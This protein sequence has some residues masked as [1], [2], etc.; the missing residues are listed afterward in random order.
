MTN[1]NFQ[2]IGKAT[3]EQQYDTVIQ[4][5]ENTM[6]MAY[7]RVVN[8]DNR[9]LQHLANLIDCPVECTAKLIAFIAGSHDTAKGDLAFQT[10]NF[11]EEC[12][13][14]VNKLEIPKDI[15]DLILSAKTQTD[16]LRLNPLHHG[17]MA[18]VVLPDLYIAELGVDE[19]TAVMMA[20]CVS[21]HH[22]LWPC[23]KRVKR[24]K[25]YFA[26][27]NIHDAYQE[28]KAQRLH[29]IQHLRNV[30]DPERSMTIPKKIPLAWSLLVSGIVINA[31]HCASREENFK[32]I[33]GGSKEPS[34]AINESSKVI[35]RYGLSK[36]KELQE[37]TFNDFGITPRPHQLK[38]EQVGKQ[39]GM[40]VLKMPTGSGKSISAFL[41]ALLHLSGF[42]MLANRR[43]TANGMHDA[44]LSFL[45]RHPQLIGKVPLLAHSDANHYFENQMEEILS[46]KETY[47]NDKYFDE[48]WKAAIALQSESLQDALT[49]EYSVATIDQALITAIASGKFPGRAYWLFSRP[50]IIDEIHSFDGRMDCILERLLYYC[51]FFGTPV[52]ALTATI[53]TQKLQRFL[54]AYAEGSQVK[55][56]GDL[57][58]TES[59]QMLHLGQDGTL[60]NTDLPCDVCDNKNIQINWFDHDT[61][62]ETIEKL[63][64]QHDR[65]AVVCATTTQVRALTTQVRDG[66]EREGF[67]VMSYHSR[68]R[69][70]DRARKE[71]TLFAYCGSN[72][73]K[74]GKIIVIA[75]QVLRESL[76]VDFDVV[77]T[78][79]QPAEDIVQILGRCGRFNRS[80]TVPTYDLYIEEPTITDDGDF[81]IGT[82]DCILL[83]KKTPIGY[84]GTQVMR[85]YA[86][87]KSNPLM[88]LPQQAQRFV[89]T[90]HI[91]IKANDNPEVPDGLPEI[92]HRFW[93]SIV[94]KQRNVFVLERADAETFI[95]PKLKDPLNTQVSSHK[96]AGITRNK[97]LRIVHPPRAIENTIEIFVRPPNWENDPLYKS[98]YILYIKQHSVSVSNREWFYKQAQAHVMKPD[99]R[100]LKNVVEMG[101]NEVR[102]V[103]NYTLVY[104]EDGLGIVYSR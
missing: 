12:F 18:A 56:N 32:L 17:P 15:K 22:G 96:L 93:R 44:L 2:L 50:M 35:Q 30:I 46:D 98:N 13:N 21:A 8:L 59:A 20:H 43:S 11:I 55:V 28:F 90:A 75:T 64:A 58:L 89:D 52:I 85:T 19:D 80:E 45:K 47:H 24:L 14:L 65:I 4:H 5:C 60:E 101:E 39:D 92:Y 31:D 68:H 37:L 6:Q 84:R 10:Q 38:L 27:K 42:V 23:I 62:V 87:L 25:E 26:N 76:D 70:K 66:L 91:L 79:L 7:Q 99:H 53:S 94:D 72:P 54:D 102:I 1:F 82:A 78:H 49:A 41:L 77:V 103:G 71:Q 3:K 100:I 74:K 51:G 33:N 81:S 48:I 61:W 67:H 95:V 36:P 40:T 73:T 34:A 63:S 83:P 69:S 29:L 86:Y 9:R 16:G 97:N 104:D 88:E 57:Q